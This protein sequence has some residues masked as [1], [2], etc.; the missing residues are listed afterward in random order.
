[1]V[2]CLWVR[3]L[4][5]KLNVIYVSVCVL[6]LVRLDVGNQTGHGLG[7]GK[8]W[9]EFKRAVSGWVSSVTFTLKFPSRPHDRV[10]YVLRQAWLL[11]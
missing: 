8:Q 7:R 4:D 6:I 5:Y 9:E 1:M 11:Q 2:L 3:W 10:L